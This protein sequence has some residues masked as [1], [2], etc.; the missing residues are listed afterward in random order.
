MGRSQVGTVALPAGALRGGPVAS[1]REK[2]ILIKN[3]E[4]W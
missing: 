3:D 2:K 1:N 4:K